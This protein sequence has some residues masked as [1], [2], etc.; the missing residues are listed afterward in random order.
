[1]G[2]AKQFEDL[3]VWQA[4]KKMV[5]DVYR[6]TRD[7]PLAKDYGFKDQLQ[8]AAVSVMANIAEGHERGGSREYVQFLYIAKGSAAEAR[9][10]VHV[11]KDLGYLSDQQQVALLDQLAGIARQLGGFIRYLG[12]GSSPS[13]SHGFS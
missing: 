7:G 9:S 2:L 10:L 1:M 12:K 5:L 11:G 3:E 4:A 8:R 6:L 13:L